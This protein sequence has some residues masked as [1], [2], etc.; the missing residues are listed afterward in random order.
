MGVVYNSCQNAVIHHENSGNGTSVG[1]PLVSIKL[2]NAICTVITRCNS[3][4]TIQ[5]CESGVLNTTGFAQPLGL[6][7][8]YEEMSSIYQGEISGT[9]DGNNSI[10]NTCASQINTLDCS[11]PVTLGAYN[12]QLSNPYSGTPNMISN[13]N[14]CAQSFAPTTYKTEILSDTPIAYWKLNEI[15]GPV[16]IDEANQHNGTYISGTIQFGVPGAITETNNTALNFQ[17]T[18]S[19][20]VDVNLANINTTPGTFVSV[21]FWMRWSGSSFDIMPF[22]FSNYS[23]WLDGGSR[24]FG[25]NTG[26]GDRYGM[27]GTSVEAMANRWV[28]VVAVM[29]NLATASDM[30]DNKLYIDGVLQTMSQTTWQQPLAVTSTPAFRIGTWAQDTTFLFDGGL[31]EFSVYNYE[32]TPAQIIRHYSAGIK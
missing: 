13:S 2:I 19:G 30:T 9:I 28:Y 29:K 11:N 22:G 16:A 14:L 1:N 27:A 4:V 20:Y 12:E 24:E 10:S 31:D 3:Q 26:N 5:N 17:N 21:E 32:L 6:N 7:S 15:S 25:F 18:G 23:L 8:N